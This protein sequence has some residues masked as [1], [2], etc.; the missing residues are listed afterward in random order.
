MISLSY[1]RKKI[2]NVS[3]EDMAQ[4]F[5]MIAGAALSPFYK[6]KYRNLWIISDEKFEARDNGYHFFKYLRTNHPEQ[7]CCFA[8]SKRAEDR[9]KV[10]EIGSVVNL[11]S[12]KHWIMYFTCQYNISSQ[13]GG[14]PNAALCSFFELMNLFK[15]KNVF[16]QH[17]VTKD[18]ND[19]ML[20]DRCRFYFVITAMDSEYRF[21][22]DSFGY[23]PG[24]VHLTGFPRF[25]NLHCSEPVANRIVIMPTWRK[26]IRYENEA[27]GELSSNFQKSEFYSKWE[28][29]L[30]SAK[31]SDLIDRYNLEILFYPHRHMQKY[32]DFLRHNISSKIKIASFGEYDIQELMKSSRMMI[33]DYSS[34]YFDMI[35]MK[36]PVLFYQFDENEFR[37]HHYQEGWFDYHNNPF[38]KSFT[39]FEHILN[40]LE[41]IICSDYKVSE[42]F[43]EAHLMEFLHWD[44]N[45]SQRVY[46]L[47]KNGKARITK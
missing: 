46:N 6:K 30:N 20:A 8:I 10:E 29:L 17:G 9:R 33:T 4:V 36:K 21:V 27:E 43:E 23:S 28:E 32:T 16:L 42:E 44:R 13:K 41:Q 31:L 34:V 5:P 35:Y 14:K 11:G 37:K 3:V 22:K 38:G 18:L 47:L 12:I 45:N 40:E 19:W 24:T 7:E 25:D 39:S 2:K 15:I 26:W 1:L